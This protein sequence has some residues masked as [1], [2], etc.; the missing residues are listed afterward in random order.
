MLLSLAGNLFRHLKVIGGDTCNGLAF[1][2]SGDD[3]DRN[4]AA[5]G[6][7]CRSGWRNGGGRTGNGQRHRGRSGI[8]GRYGLLR[9]CCQCVGK[10]EQNP[11]AGTK[12]PLLHFE[13]PLSILRASWAK[14]AH[15]RNNS[16]KRVAEYRS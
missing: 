5:G 8:G 4:H 2:I 11:E 6:S 10:K 1:V 14:A 16:A 15:H 13:S 12:F 9:P 7:K 3:F